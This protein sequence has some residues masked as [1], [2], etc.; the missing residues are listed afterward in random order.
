MV[1]F[2][3]DLEARTMMSQGNQLPVDFIVSGTCGDCGITLLKVFEIEFVPQW[4]AIVVA[5]TL[6]T[7]DL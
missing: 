4:I 2:Q 3:V 1:I 7:V 6:L 5:V